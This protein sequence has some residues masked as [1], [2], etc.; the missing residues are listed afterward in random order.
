MQLTNICRDIGED[1]HKDRIYLPSDEYSRYNLTE[2]DFFN[3]QCSP[4]FKE[5]LEFNIQ[6]ALSYYQ[7]ADKG[8]PYLTADSRMTVQLMSTNYRRIL[9]KIRQNDYDVFTKRASLSLS[10]KLLAVPR[11]FL[12]NFAKT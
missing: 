1:L 3:Q 9:Y 4:Q 7:S 10:E 2:Q 8:I 5:Y 12:R 6:R 11:A